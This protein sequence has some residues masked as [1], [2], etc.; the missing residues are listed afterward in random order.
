MAAFE[1]SKTTIGKI[2]QFFTIRD[3]PYDLE[4]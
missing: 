4:K 1:L 3:D 2:F